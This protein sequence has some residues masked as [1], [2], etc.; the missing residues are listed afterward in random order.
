MHGDP[1]AMVAY[2]IGVLL[3]TKQMKSEYPDV[4]Q[5]WY[6][7]NNGELGTFTN[8]KLYGFK[9]WNGAR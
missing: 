9:V 7:D 8:I 5:P 6:D 3:M 4:T 1:L 2:V